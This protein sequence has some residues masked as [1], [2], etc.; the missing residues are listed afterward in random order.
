MS[1]KKLNYV[2]ESTIEK[3]LKSC[4]WLM[5]LGE[6]SNGKSYSAKNLITRKCI[7]E[8]KEFIYLRRYDL[9]VK[10]SLCVSYFGDSPVEAITD[11]EY[12]C[13][14]V[15]RKNIWLSNVADDGKVTRGKKIGYCHA[16]SAAEHYKSL[17]FPDVDYIIYEE[18]VSMDGRYLYNET[19]KLQQYVSTI[20][21]N[22]KG[23]VILIGNTISRICPYYRDWDL[24]VAKQKLGTIENYVFHND[25]GEDTKMSIYLTDSLNY[26]SGMFFGLAA[27]NITKGA[28]EVQEQPHLPKSYLK[29][30]NLYTIVLEYNEFK[31][32]C[33]LLQ[34]KEESNNI[35]WY[36]QP[37][38]T[39]VKS[40]TRVISNKFSPDPYYSLSLRRPINDNERQVF[41]MFNKGK[42][43]FSD[44][45][46]G[47]EFNNIINH[48]M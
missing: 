1:N 42:V 21:R 19:Q 5:M 23:K 48:M 28:Y 35:F 8:G 25:N 45:L 12:H 36:V 6:R 43:C 46:T 15:Y 41:N 40:G 47:T 37:K 11:G 33:E 26:N 30:N 2:K 32:L 13:I 10:D 44:N 34:D 17:A 27:K 9:D 39:E 4:D 29:Y 31:F 22:R 38:T 24:K 7:E 3:I 14:D 20:F 16:L 18:L